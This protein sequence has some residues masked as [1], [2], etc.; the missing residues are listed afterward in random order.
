MLAFLNKQPLLSFSSPREAF[1]FFF[2]QVK[3]H[4]PPRECCLPNHGRPLCVGV[5]KWGRYSIIPSCR[6][7]VGL[8]LFP[9]LQAFCV[10]TYKSL[11]SPHFLPSPCAPEM[12]DSTSRLLYHGFVCGC[13][14]WTRLKPVTVMGFLTQSDWCARCQLRCVCACNMHVCERR[15]MKI[16]T[17]Q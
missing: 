3:V 13:Q 4:S 14:N 9:T 16:Q 17:F 7:T 11:I 8:P 15:R 10:H 5:A 1:S 6:N 12:F 2:T